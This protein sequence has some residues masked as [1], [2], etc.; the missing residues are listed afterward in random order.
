M[1]H[2]ENAMGLLDAAFAYLNILHPTEVEKK[3]TREA[4]TTLMTY[5]RAEAGLS[6]SLKGHVMEN[7][8]CDFNDACGI[9]D[10]E[11]SFIEQGHQVGLKDD[12]RYHGL[13][14]FEK[15]TASTLKARAFTS[16]PLVKDTQSTVLRSSQRKRSAPAADMEMKTTAKKKKE[17]VK[18]EKDL[19]RE[20]YVNKNNK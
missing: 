17:N 19:K 7:H 15:K 2:I 16:H 14:N 12:R 18:H 1:N 5:W 13:K 6:V 11:E 4:V 20:N 3:K 9:G 8:A 10:K